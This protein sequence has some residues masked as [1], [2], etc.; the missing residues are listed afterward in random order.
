MLALQRSVRW[1]A[2]P[3]A[4]LRAMGALVLVVVSGAYAPAHSLPPGRAWSA[5]IDTLKLPGHTYGLEPTRLE[6]D[7]QGRLLGF[8]EAVGGI[9][10]DMYVLRWQDSTWVSL[11]HL[12]YGTK[13]VRPAPSP[14]G[15]YHLIWGGL[16]AIMT[17]REVTY[18]VMNQLVADT[19][20][21]PDTVTT[22]W[23]SGLKYAAAASP[24]RRWAAA[25][26]YGDLRLLYSSAPGNWHEVPV[27][28]RGDRGMALATL[29]DTTAL[30]AWKDWQLGPGAGILRGSTW[31][32]T[33]A[34][35]MT[36]LSDAA[37][38]FRLRP[39][40]GYWL[41]WATQK[42]FVGIA[43]YRDG[44]WSAAGSIQCAYLRPGAHRAQSF[45]QMSRDDGEYPAVGWMAV[46]ALN[47]LT[48]VCVCVPGDS[49]FTV[50]ENLPGSEEGVS[51]VVARDRNGDVWVAWGAPEGMGWAHTY[52]SA[53]SSAPTVTGA[54][55]KRFINW[56]LSEPTPGS[57][58]AVLRARGEEPYEEIARVKAGASAAMTWA[59]F[60]P[61]AGTLRYRI[62]RECLDRQYQWLSEEMGWPVGAPP[63]PHSGSGLRLVIASD[64][65][66][67][68]AIRLEILNASPGPLD[69][70]VY[71][72]RGRLVLQQRSVA[73]GTGQDSI[74][75]NLAA[76]A[77]APAP[78]LYFLRVVDASGQIS[79]SAKLVLLR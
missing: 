29:D 42:D 45:V 43:S 22:F 56:T 48:S 1:A 19:L 76:A 52:T 11:D 46:S 24:V 74:L 6:F 3:T 60:E 2:R 47:G 57:W 16:E 71:D 77:G 39:S 20:T 53:T 50:A 54:G 4:A 23:A 8:V 55:T 31:I 75:V 25:E 58:W 13:G 21:V 65:P 70:R 17:D 37:P 49:G 18:L 72:L 68:A 38:L 28:G 7:P 26:D 33:S 15:T 35:P 59:D 10:R 69:V 51:P 27:G 41:S 32:P 44:V 14:E 66:S 40:G 5:I 12:G 36:D 79:P 9:G 34:P 78:G 73:T 30:L 67:S 63:L 61:P 64:N 62:R